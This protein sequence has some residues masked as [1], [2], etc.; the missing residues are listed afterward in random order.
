MSFLDNHDQ[1]QRIQHPD[2][3]PHQVSLALAVLFTLQGIPSIYY[4]TEQGLAGTVNPDG[5]PDLSANE[6]S[7]EALWG[8]P[9]AFATNTAAFAQVQ[10]LARL[11]ESEPPLRYGRLYFREVSGNGEDFGHSSGQGGIIAFSRILVD[12]EVVTVANTGSQPFSGAV[13]VD[14]DIHATPHQMRVAYSN[15]ATTGSGTVRRIQNAKFHGNGQ[16]TSATAAAL[17]VI[18]APGEAQV[19]VPA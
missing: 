7:R 14:R 15:R 1:H 8:K 6:S 19:L 12:R 4:G 18:L 13:I 9:N 3:P 17:D 16:V 2:T 11:R 10:A 5:T